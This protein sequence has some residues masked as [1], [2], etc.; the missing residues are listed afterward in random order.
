MK[1][2]SVDLIVSLLKERDK[3]RQVRA[4]SACV[5]KSWNQQCNVFSVVNSQLTRNLRSYFDRWREKDD[6]SGLVYNRWCLE[7]T[8]SLN[9][10]SIPGS[11]FPK[12]PSSVHRSI[13]KEFFFM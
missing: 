10:R 11:V 12:I 1:S 3:S 7:P 6:L 9:S 2:K 13:S 4:R 5:I 8:W